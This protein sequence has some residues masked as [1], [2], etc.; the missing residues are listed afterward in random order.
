MFYIKSSH[1]GEVHEVEEMPQFGGWELATKEE[2]DKQE[3]ELNKP[4]NIVR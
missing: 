3:A 2:Y 1:T 4:L